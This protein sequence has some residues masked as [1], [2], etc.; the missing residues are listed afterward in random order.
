[1][2]E[3]AISLFLS[4]IQMS[5]SSRNMLMGAPRITFTQI[6]GHL[7]PSIYK[8]KRPYVELTPSAV[9]RSLT[10]GLPGGYQ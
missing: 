10:Q 9:A 4:P 8:I 7:S 5:N 1:M 6:A 3:R 2:L